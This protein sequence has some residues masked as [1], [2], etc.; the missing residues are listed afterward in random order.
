VVVATKRPD[1]VVPTHDNP[2]DAV[3]DPSAKETPQS[4]IV[5]F[6]KFEL[7]ML[8]VVL[9]TVPPVG[10]VTAVVP[11]I[12]N[13]V[14]N[15]PENTTFPPSVMVLLFAMPVPPL[16][17]AKGRA[18]CGA[19][20]LGDTWAMEPIQLPKIIIAESKSERIIYKSP[21]Q[22]WVRQ[23]YMLWLMLEA[24]HPLP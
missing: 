13:V 7:A 21:S 6:A 18:I 16:A 22:K 14:P 3:T 2:G 1:D 8:D 15:A 12:V 9:R 10:S 5:E 19:E 4:E 17:A 23:R 20:K 11:V 24:S